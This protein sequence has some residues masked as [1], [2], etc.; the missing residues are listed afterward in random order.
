MA[1]HCPVPGGLGA[2]PKD[3]RSRHAWRDLLEQV[4]P[5]RANAVLEWGKTGGVATRARQVIDKTGAHRIG[6][7]G[8]HDRY[9]AG[10]LE[11]PLPPRPTALPLTRRRRCVERAADAL[12]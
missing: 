12:C 7:E 9:A 8:E 3:R 6:D 4:Q 11:Q 2:I 10:R 5:F 1:P